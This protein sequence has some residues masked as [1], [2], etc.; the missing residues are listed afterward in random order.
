MFQPDIYIDTLIKHLQK[1]LGERL[2]YVGLQGSYLR[3][4]ATEN[5]DL[6][7][8]TVIRDITVSDLHTYRQ[9]THSLPSPEKACGF[10]CGPEELQHWNPLE[11]CHLVHTTKDYFGRLSSL[12]PAYTGRD[13][14]SFVKLS[15]GNL[16]HEICHRYIHAPAEENWRSLPGTYKS[17]FFILQNLHYLESGHFIGTKEEMLKTLT[18][19][20]RQVLETALSLSRGEPFDFGTAFSLL[21]SWCKEALCHTSSLTGSAL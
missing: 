12:V 1:A 13:V 14:C 17:V 8:M 18:G 16:Y 10:I 9:I 11:I 7:I 4:E 6:D 21:F 20:D 2:V 3:G 15:L 5:S 19:K